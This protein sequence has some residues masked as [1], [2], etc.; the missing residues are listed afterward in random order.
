[1][2]VILRDGQGGR[3]SSRKHG[4]ICWSFFFWRTF[5]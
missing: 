5:L 4:H 2:S 3:N 1:M